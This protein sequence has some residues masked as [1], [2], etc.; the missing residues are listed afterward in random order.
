MCIHENVNSPAVQALVEAMVP[1]GLIPITL[2]G[3]IGATRARRNYTMFANPN[4]EEGVR[5]AI[6]DLYSWHPNA[7]VSEQTANRLRRAGWD[8]DKVFDVIEGASEH[9]VGRS[10]PDS[11]DLDEKNFEAVYARCVENGYV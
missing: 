3:H 8:W 7:Y 5:R 4:N 9:I 6:H 1:K 10:V 11:L 2:V